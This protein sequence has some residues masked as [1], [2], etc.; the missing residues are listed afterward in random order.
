MTDCERALKVLRDELARARAAR[1][2]HQIRHGER[3]NL[4]AAAAGFQIA[5]LRNLIWQI[6]G[7]WPP[8]SEGRP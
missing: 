8:K 2:Y 6:T 5:W 3:D 7:E 4:E 1:D